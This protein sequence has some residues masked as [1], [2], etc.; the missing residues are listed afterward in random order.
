MEGVGKT[1]KND[2]KMTFFKVDDQGSHWTDQ[3]YRFYSKIIK[4]WPFFGFYRENPIWAGV[5]KW[6]KTS[7]NDEKRTLFKGIMGV[8]TGEV[9]MS[10]LGSKIAKFDH[11]WPFFENPVVNPYPPGRENVQR[12]HLSKTGIMVGKSALKNGSFF[13][14]KRGS[15]G[16]F[17]AR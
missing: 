10:I 1:S 12:K 5:P 13:D 6:P 16:V 14:Q 11:F 9:K 4:F 7:K 8:Y 15:E 2:E 3:K 17:L